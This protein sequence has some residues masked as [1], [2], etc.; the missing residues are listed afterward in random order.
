[1][2]RNKLDSPQS[3]CGEFITDFHRSVSDSRVEE[4]ITF[5]LRPTSHKN[6]C[7]SFFIIHLNELPSYDTQNVSAGE[8]V[9]AM[10]LRFM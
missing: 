5:S 7:L 4:Y 3:F 10:Y 8:N 2:N 6:I 9:C 1:M